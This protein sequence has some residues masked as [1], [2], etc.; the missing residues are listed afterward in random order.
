MSSVS[1][2]L[3]EFMPRFRGDGY[4]MS[5]VTQT[6]LRSRIIRLDAGD[7]RYGYGEFISDPGLD[8]KEV[9]ALE[10]AALAELTDLVLEDLPVLTRRLR[11]QDQKLNGMT[12]GLETAYFDLLA[13]ANDVQ[14]CALFGGRMCQDVPDYL[15]LSCGEPAVMAARIQADGGS[16]EVIQIK[17]DGKDMDTDISRI[18]AVLAVLQPNQTVLVDFNGALSPSSARTVFAQ[19]SDSRIMWEEPCYTY[20]E[21]RDL[22]DATGARLLFDQC[23]KSLSHITR[24]CGDAVMTAACIKPDM[25]G[26]LGVAQVARDVCTASGIA[27]RVDGLWCG[28][29]ATSAILHLAVGTPP[30]L[31]IA[32][33]DLREPL[34]LDEDWGGI[35]RTPGD[36]IAPADG[37]GHGVIPPATMWM[38]S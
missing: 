12:F 37:P 33:C 1:F 17:L 10:D 3:A 32:G 18:D 27:V 13:R 29:V 9:G 26:G 19:Y 2:T 21:N 5:Y 35:R 20:E 30:D 34:V 15:S 38:T 23:L 24:A 22:A 28:S 6:V 16:R 14:L 36:R 8:G 4:V 7:G 31:L 11:A 25:L